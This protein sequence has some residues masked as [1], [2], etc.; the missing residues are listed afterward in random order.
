MF[1]FLHR[2]TTEQPAA[3]ITPEEAIAVGSA[4]VID[5]SPL[6]GGMKPLVENPELAG[7]QETDTNHQEA[8]A[9]VAH[10][11]V[12]ST[13]DLPAEAP[14]QYNAPIETPTPLAGGSTADVQ[15][16][17]TPETTTPES[18]P[19]GQEV[20]LN[21]IPQSTEALA[22]QVVE[23]ASAPDKIDNQ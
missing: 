11:A 2:N 4:A 12:T 3:P 6:Q 10:Q 22:P 21:P 17:V 5:A 13:V 20:S 14:E 8:V 7:V 1:G 16:G 18:T 23:T 9:D 19:A 15:W